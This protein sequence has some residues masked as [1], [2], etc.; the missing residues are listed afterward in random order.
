LGPAGTAA[1][2]VDTF[3]KRAICAATV[4][5]CGELAGAPTTTSTGEVLFGGKSR[6]SASSTWRALALC[7]RTLAVTP[8]SLICANGIPSAIRK[9]R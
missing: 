7:G 5:T 4:L 6:A 3:G 9:P 1:A 2:T 8:A